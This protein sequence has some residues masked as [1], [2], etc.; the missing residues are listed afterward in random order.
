[1]VLTAVLLVVPVTPALHELCRRHD[2]NPLLTSRHDGR[3]KNLAEAFQSRLE[4]FC[5]EWE[6]CRAKEE[7]VPR[8]RDGIAVLLVGREEF[9]FDSEPS[10]AKE[11]IDAVICARAFIPSGRVVDADVSSFGDLYLGEGAV[12][13]AGLSSRDI[14]LNPGSSV[15]RWLHACRTVYLRRG[16]TVHNRL[17]ADQSIVLEPECVFQRMHAPVILALEDSRLASRDCSPPGT[18]PALDR[19]LDAPATPSHAPE[20]SGLF[21]A[22][23]RMRVR[24]D[25]VLA[26]GESLCA[27]VIATG[28][29]H[30]ERG[31]CFFGSAKSYRD[32]VVEAGARVYGSIAYGGTAYL[33]TNSFLSGPL[34]AET[35][36]HLSPGC[37]VGKPDS[38][39]TIAACGAWIRP[40]CR[41]HGTIWARVQG[42]IV[43]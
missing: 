11:C 30:I 34:L 41:I 13:R 19:N 36:V 28:E 38:L 22:R 17:S 37:C 10:E 15:L 39:T 4:P 29:F 35:D 5:Q 18:M 42:K 8:R 3:I 23:P 7:I 32:T 9:D 6:R 27:N 14:I 20:E 21:A 33:G 43:A 2:A 31:A 26:A 12:L 25:F 40:G 16:S 24:G 1:V